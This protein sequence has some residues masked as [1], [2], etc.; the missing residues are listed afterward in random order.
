MQILGGIFAATLS[1]LVWMAMPSF[2]RSE[3]KLAYVTDFSLYTCTCLRPLRACGRINAS[4]CDCDDHSFS[5]L[6]RSGSSGLVHGTH[7]TVWY[8]SPLNVALLLNNSEV[9][10]LSLV[11]C[12]A[13]G[14]KAFSY[15]Y[16][17][18]QRLEKLSVAYPHWHAD[19]SSHDVVIG[20]EPAGPL[21]A[22]ARVAIIH[23][24]VLTGKRTLKAYT[25]QAH[26]DSE[27][28]FPFPN[29]HLARAGLPDAADTF[30]T[31]L[32]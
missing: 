19:P 8:T 30:I 18:V 12:D 26:R 2:L 23:L 16:F 3:F 25:V 24:S 6:Q 28:G 14:G 21:P 10:H 7:I 13:A 32:Y 22:E 31:F 27:G 4:E 5:A 20:R 11:K 17:A 9:H 29:L 15:D 1:C